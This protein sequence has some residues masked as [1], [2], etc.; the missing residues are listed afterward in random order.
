M[1]DDR[2]KLNQI[3]ETYT[4]RIRLLQALHPRFSND[5]S[6]S[7]QN[8]GSRLHSDSDST[9]QTLEVS[10]IN[11][12]DDEVDDEVNDFLCSIQRELSADEF[13]QS[14]S[15]KH[16]LWR[17]PG[18]DH[19]SS[20]GRRLQREVPLSRLDLQLSQSLEPYQHQ[21]Q[22][23]SGAR[24]V[25]TQTHQFYETQYAPLVLAA[26]Q[27]PISG[28]LHRE[29]SR[30][31]HMATNSRITWRAS[32][33]VQ[34][35]GRARSNTTL[36]Q[37][38]DV[39]SSARRISVDFQPRPRSISE[40]I[41]NST[42]QDLASPKSVSEEERDTLSTPASPA[43]LLVRPYLAMR[44]LLGTFASSKRTG[45]GTFLTKSLHIPHSIWDSKN[46]KIKGEEEKLQAYQLLIAELTNLG[47]IDRDDLDSLF[48]CLESFERAMDAAQNILARKMGSHIITSSTIPVRD[49]SAVSVKKVAG[50][51][52]SRLLKSTTL[53]G[54]KPPLSL[55]NDSSEY[56]GNHTLFQ[57]T[58]AQL[59]QLAQLIGTLSLQTRYEKVLTDSPR[60]SQYTLGHRLS[61]CQTTNATGPYI[62]QGGRLFR[63]CN[64]PSLETS[65]IYLI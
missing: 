18:H 52:L 62:Q 10:R 60:S 55:A 43:E 26:R 4:D 33:I 7:S 40:Y 37:E 63:V 50:R 25:H 36:K 20:F 59:F 2:R 29:D 61:F 16:S 5:G 23:L 39:T 24:S 44:L 65:E 13:Q 38:Q 54:D 12:A 46:V 41:H 8:D 57:S 31:A 17:E 45:Q 19:R 48:D 6:T 56:E 51:S 47:R 42:S 11:D 30:S 34:D 27:R 1:H 22:F 53:T 49:E 35:L 64:A 58:T 21:G 15:P 32:P 14:D 9:V 3:H 28:P